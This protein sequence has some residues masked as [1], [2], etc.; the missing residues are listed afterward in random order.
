MAA[1]GLRVPAERTR[2]PAGPMHAWRPGRP[3]CPAGSVL[4]VN[5]TYDNTATNPY[6]PN[7]PPQSV[8]WGEGTTDEMYLVGMTYVP[9]RDGDED[10]IMGQGITTDIEEVVS[11]GGS[12]LFLPFPNPASEQVLINFYLHESQA[13]NMELIDVK[14]KVV[15]T[16]QKSSIYPAGNHN[17][18]FD[19]KDLSTGIYTI[20]LGNT[21]M[22]LSR[23]LVVSNQ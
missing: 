7:F 21:A 17:I 23:P 12:R 19:V 3:C 1:T 20:R 15:K 8:T 16:I 22:V 18:E 4:H 9:Y 11:E 13:I 2:I 14:G 5:A 6:N 10:I